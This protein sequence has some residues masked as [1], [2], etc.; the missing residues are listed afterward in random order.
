[1]YQAACR[2][3]CKRMPSI[4][5][6]CI[7]MSGIPIS[8]VVE[9]DCVPVEDLA[10]NQL[11][12]CEYTDQL[13][14]MWLGETIANWTGLTTEGVKP[15]APFYTDAD[16]G[17]D[18]NISWKDND[19]IDFVFQ[20]P[21]LSDDDTDIEYVYL[22]LLQE[23][24]TIMLTPQQIADGW[25]AH[26]NDYIWVSNAQARN[27]MEL[28]TLPPVTSMGSANEHY[29]QIDAQLTTEIFGA[30]APGMPGQALLMG[31]L[32]IRTTAG[33]YSA[34]AAQFFVVLYS[35]ATQ[36]DSTLSSREQ[37][38]WMVEEARH[39][40]PDTSKTADIIDFVLEDY[41]ANPD[42]DD[43]ELTRDR[44]YERYHENAREYGFVYRGWT[45]SS[46]NFA[47]GLL[48]LLYGEG[49]FR[50]TVQI[51][52]LSGWDSDNGTATVGGLLGLMQGY[53]MLVAQF[54][55]EQISDRYRIHRTRPTMPNYLPDDSRAQDTFTLMAERML[56]LIEQAIIE[57][58]GSVDGDVWTLPP[59]PTENQLQLNP[60]EL[61]SQRSANLRVAAEGG[62]IEVSVSGEVPKSRMQLMVDGV[63]H[64]FSGQEPKHPLRVYHD[65][66]VD[67]GSEIAITV[68]YARDVEVAVIR[69]I[70]GNTNAFSQIEAQLLI[71]GE[72]HPT[73]EGTTLSQL[74]DST[75]PYQIFDFQLPEPILAQGIQLIATIQVD[76]YFPEVV[77]LELDALS[78]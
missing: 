44:I 26:M 62:T 65:S 8:G 55:D 47:A 76:S 49:D 70:E 15:D 45:E 51:G 71:D 66:S 63:E 12:R 29:L 35:L 40:I 17:L 77:I 72:W 24:S 28:G 68:T 39:Y 69:L 25:R 14:A 52:T 23:N 31:D 27:L 41:L 56:P 9:S 54:P 61:L 43:W 50:R 5:F 34:H 73:P 60:L 2:V 3:I 38:I 59:L 4:L 30:L 6:L 20:N 32:P 11:S 78:Q 37:N 48:A 19:V 1:M 21:W 33:S 53:D 46:V 13:R 58:G 67:A 36:V 64:D 16:W 42:K 10:A 74:P 57:A 75:I 18:Q 22:H 7:F